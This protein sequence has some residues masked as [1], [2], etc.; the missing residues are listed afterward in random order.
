[1]ETNEEYEDNKSSVDYNQSFSFITE[2]RDDDNISILSLKDNNSNEFDASNLAPKYFNSKP[3]F[4]INPM[5]NL[6]NKNWPLFNSIIPNIPN[7][8]NALY[9]FIPTHLKIVSIDKNKKKIL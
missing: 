5:L 9:D 2:P 8:Y 1:M 4:N 3:T 6:C 7:E